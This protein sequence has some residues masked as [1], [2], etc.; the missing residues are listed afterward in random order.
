MFIAPTPAKLQGP[1][2]GSLRPGGL[3]Q[4]QVKQATET[5]RT[6]IDTKLIQFSTQSKATLLL[7]EFHVV[8]FGSFPFWAEKSLQQNPIYYLIPVSTCIGSGLCKSIKVS[9][10]RNQ[11]PMYISS[12]VTSPVHIWRREKIL[13]N[14]KS[15]VQWYSYGLLYTG[16]YLSIL[17]YF[18]IYT[19]FHIEICND[20]YVEKTIH[21]FIHTY[22]NILYTQFHALIHTYTLYPACLSCVCVC[23][24][25][26]KCTYVCICQMINIYIKY[27][28]LQRQY[29]IDIRYKIVIFCIH[30]VYIYINAWT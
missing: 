8:T 1:S 5:H 18:D 24:Y 21:T 13:P 3:F 16:T 28:Y 17:Q 15:D 7:S 14:Q 25:L 6:Q 29:I 22:I 20:L 23:V 11:V 27:I 26:N 30:S 12:A 9:W 4:I 19:F 10:N 2:L